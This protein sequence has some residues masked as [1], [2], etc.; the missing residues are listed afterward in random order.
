MSMVRTTSSSAEGTHE[1]SRA[2]LRHGAGEHCSACSCFGMVPFI[3]G[4]V[5]TN[6]NFFPTL[7][8]SYLTPVG[9]VPSNYGFWL[10][11][12][13]LTT[14]TLLTRQCWWKAYANSW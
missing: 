12:T 5:G 11:S 3:R 1:S 4:S 2:P 13:T 6:F 14:R 7:H 8:I 9:D 10:Q